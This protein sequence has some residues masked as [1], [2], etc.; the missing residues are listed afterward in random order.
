M[1]NVHHLEV[2]NETIAGVNSRFAEVIENGILR[3]QAI[4]IPYDTRKL[5]N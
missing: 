2:D 1:D 3:M 4:T 5:R